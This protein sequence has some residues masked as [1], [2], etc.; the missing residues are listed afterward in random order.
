MQGKDLILR[1]LGLVFAL[2]LLISCGPDEPG[3]TAGQS[4]GKKGS[5]ATGKG[6]GTE[7][8]DPESGVAEGAVSFVISPDDLLAEFLE[9]PEGAR[10]RY[11]GKWIETSGSVTW[12]GSESVKLEGDGGKPLN[13][14]F[15]K[16]QVKTVKAGERVDVRGRVEVTLLGPGYG[17]RAVVRLA[18]CQLLGRD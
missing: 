10:S 4:S 11:Q 18:D 2:L 14:G 8:S 5:S 15:A 7:S 13:C 3:T 17:D 1:G 6:D 16:D 12:T 9:D